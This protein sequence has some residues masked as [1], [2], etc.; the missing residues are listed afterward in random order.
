MKKSPLFLPT[1]T[2]CTPSQ[3]SKNENLKCSF[4]PYLN[5]LHIGRWNHVVFA[6]KFPYISKRINHDFIMWS[7]YIHNVGLKAWL[8]WLRVQKE[9]KVEFM[10]WVTLSKVERR[11]SMESQWT[12]NHVFFTNWMITSFFWEGSKQKR[13]S[14]QFMSLRKVVTSMKLWKQNHVPNIGRWSIEACD[15]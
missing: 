6:P 2:F 1:T 4:Y 8:A 14:E 12:I 13:T 5:R 10:T 15:T 9:L 7:T 11:V 3:T